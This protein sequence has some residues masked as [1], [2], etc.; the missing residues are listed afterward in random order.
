MRA[1]RGSSARACRET[2]SSWIAATSS[3]VSRPPASIRSAIRAAR[4]GSIQVRPKGYGSCRDHPIVGRDD[5]SALGI[6]GPRQ[7][8][9][10][11]DP[12][13][14]VLAGPGHGQEA[15][16]P[17]PDRHRAPGGITDVALD[18]GVDEVERGG[19]DPLHAGQEFGPVAS[20][21]DVQEGLRRAGIGVQSRPAQGHGRSEPIGSAEGVGHD[22]PVDGCP[23]L[24]LH[25]RAPADADPLD[26]LVE[27]LP[28]SP[29]PIARGIVGVDVFHEE[30][31]HVG[32]ERGHPPGD[33]VVVPDQHGGDAGQRRAGRPQTGG[34]DRGEV[35]DGRRSQ[36]EMRIVGEDRF[37]AGGP[38]ARED[39][40]VAAEIPAGSDSERRERRRRP[41]RRGP[42]RQPHRQ[43]GPEGSPP[44]IPAPA[45]PW[46][47]GS[48]ARSPRG[49]A[50]RRRAPLPRPR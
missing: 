43:P 18:V 49:A 16:G 6:E 38:G 7:A 37:A 13:P 17:R 32:L 5:V 19:A 46:R 42:S 23:H 47:T 39:P 21:G 41:G 11:Q 8:R 25:V 1:S 29:V 26:P 30:V 50:A 31:L 45:S 9:G 34:V 2:R 20:P 27:P 35:P 22:R 48:S 3:G 12:A 33:P 44:R 36:P 4:N 24:Q 15:V 10:G 28:L 14:V 40:G